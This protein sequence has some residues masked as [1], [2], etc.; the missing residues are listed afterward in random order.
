MKKFQFLIGILA[1]SFLYAFTHEETPTI[2]IHTKHHTP[3]VIEYNKVYQISDKSFE[4]V[5]NLPKGES[6]VVDYVCMTNATYYN[7]FLKNKNIDAIEPFKSGNAMSISV[8]SLHGLDK[9]LKISNDS[10]Q[11]M[12][13]E[14]SHFSSF[15]KVDSTDAR[16]NLHHEVNYLTDLTGGQAKNYS[17]KHYPHDTLYCL[18]DLSINNTTWHSL[19]IVPFKLVFKKD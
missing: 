14:G 19:T 6:V 17:F 10:R 7:E 5:F 15:I 4:L 12:L 18:V 3:Q 11:P 9:S 1:L 16:Y 8:N 2:T 13:Y